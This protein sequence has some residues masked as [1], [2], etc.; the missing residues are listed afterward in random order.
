MVAR[1]P[2]SQALLVPETFD[3]TPAQAA[4]FD[5]GPQT[6]KL[7]L[8]VDGVFRDARSPSAP[9]RRHPP[10]RR[11]TCSPKSS[12]PWTPRN[13]AVARH[14]RRGDR[15]L[16]RLPRRHQN[17]HAVDARE[18]AVA[19]RRLLT[20]SRPPPARTVA[21]SS[22]THPN[23]TS[24]AASTGH[25]KEGLTRRRFGITRF[26]LT[27]VSASTKIIAGKGQLLCSELVGLIVSDFSRSCAPASRSVRAAAGETVVGAWQTTTGPL[28]ITWNSTPTH[29]DVR[30]R[31]DQV[32]RARAAA[33]VVDEGGQVKLQLSRCAARPGHF[34]RRP[35][36]PS[37]FTRRGAAQESK[38]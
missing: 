18:D 35:R 25:K 3:L 28:T 20:T 22:S 23:A 19:D 21:P 7:R 8:R 17:Q 16:A 9:C 4:A 30:R 32:H 31:A 34:G 10:P 24:S 14:A 38:G 15:R 26:A 13:G 27:R 11:A 1:R 5:R 6:S 12:T 2:E 36:R 29:R 33:L 37:T